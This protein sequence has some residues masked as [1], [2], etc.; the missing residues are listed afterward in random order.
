MI[1]CLHRLQSDRGRWHR[2]NKVHKSGLPVAGAAKCSSGKR[3]LGPSP[4]HHRRNWWA[5][6]KDWGTGN[7]GNKNS[8]KRA[9]GVDLPR[10]LLGKKK[11]TLF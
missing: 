11:L 3:C 7:S 10:V 4:D 9:G 2:I 5:R 1:S 8:K 6:K